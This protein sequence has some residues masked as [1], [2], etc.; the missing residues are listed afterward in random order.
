MQR[1]LVGGGID[2]TVVGTGADRREAELPFL[3]FP[4]AR[5]VRHRD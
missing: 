5:H 2:P 4:G 1:G 3:E